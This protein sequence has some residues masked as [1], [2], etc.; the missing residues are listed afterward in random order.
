LTET[1]SFSP[2]KLGVFVAALIWFLFSFHE[3]FKA[4]VNINEYAFFVGPSSTWVLITDVSGVIGLVVRAIASFIAVVGLAL[5]LFKSPS[6]PSLLKILKTVLVLEAIYWLSL[7]ISGIWGVLPSAIGGIGSAGDSGISFNL[8]F[9]VNTGIPCLV[10]AIA[11][12][13]VLIKLFFAL[14]PNKPKS[15][16]VKWG[17]ITMAVYVIVFW[18]NNTCNWLTA[19]LYHGSGIILDYP[20]N[21]FS[22]ALT[23]FG[24]LGLALYAVYFTKKS[25]GIDS[26]GKVDWQKV[27]TIVVLLGLYFDIIYVMWLLLGSVGGWN[28]WYAWFLGHNMDLWIV[29]LPLAGLPLLFKQKSDEK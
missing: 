3:L 28:E 19:A 4:F 6:K 24:L 10:E 22:F 14:N 8:V 1:K 16:V 7:L 13:I 9:L 29:A 27:G 15:A 21:I 20:A 23:A 12:P 26:L 11:L 25:V 2:L 5:Y 17:L 18:L